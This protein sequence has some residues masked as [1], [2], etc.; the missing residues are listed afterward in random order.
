MIPREYR[1]QI[2]PAQFFHEVLDHRWYMAEKAGHDVPMAEAVQSYIKNVLPQYQLDTKTV[3]ELNADADA[4]V[5][6]DEY[7]YDDASNN[8]A[9]TAPAAGHDD[10][11]NPEDDPDA[12]VWAH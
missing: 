10:G 2:E 3:N 11:Y 12:A 1:S 6:D 4:G 7:T 5:V 8:G 9:H